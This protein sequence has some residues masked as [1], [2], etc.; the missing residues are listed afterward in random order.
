[1]REYIHHHVRVGQAGKR[2]L[3]IVFLA[4]AELLRV[5]CARVRSLS[6]T[7][8]RSVV[9]LSTVARA[10]P[11]SPAFHSASMVLSHPGQHFVF[12]G[13]TSLQA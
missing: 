7:D 10:W 4:T 3:D 12:Q 9:L 8:M 1:M 13:A 6:V 11:T 2:L 5:C